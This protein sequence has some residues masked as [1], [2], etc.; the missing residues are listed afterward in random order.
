MCVTYKEL[1]QAMKSGDR[2]YSNF[3]DTYGFLVVM[4]VLDKNEF[5]ECVKEYDSEYKRRTGELSA[6][7]MLV[8]RAGFS[9]PKKFGF[10]QVIAALYK[11]GM[12]FLP[13]FAED[14]KYFTSLLCSEKFTNIFKYFCGENWLYLG[15]DG[16]RFATTS[17]P[18]HRDWLTKTEL[19]KCNLYFN[20]VPFI[21][22]RFLIIPGSQNICDTYGKRIQKSISWPM[23]NKNPSGMNENDYIPDVINPRRRFGFLSILRGKNAF[24]VP[25]IKIKIR[26]GDLILFDQRCLHC[27]E[28]SYPR[29]TRR[30]MTFLI[31]K[32]SYDLPEN[33]EALERH[34]RDEIMKDLL[35]LIVNE[36]NH[37]GCPPWGQ[38]YENSTLAHSNHYIK[39]SKVDGAAQYNHASI[40]TSS[41]LSFESKL[42]FEYYAK[43][44]EQYRQRYSKSVRSPGDRMAESFSYDDVHLGI[45]SQNI[46]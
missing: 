29:V 30:L 18:W 3:Y 2:K 4:S 13:Y 6:W 5:N 7:E 25:H 40:H 44:G 22:G 21:G 26:R 9:G 11:R 45:N 10:K 36:R 42:N 8:N 19:L 35:D 16:S 34:S 28:T 33:H 43:I 24:D 32:N 31:A 23:Q 15:S 39:I 46:R 1:S 41:G 20:T 27:I 17:F 38:F 12:A 37:I 14:S